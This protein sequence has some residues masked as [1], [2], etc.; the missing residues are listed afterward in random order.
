MEDT[1]PPRFR[2]ALIKGVGSTFKSITGNVSL[3][4]Y[5]T[6][7]INKINRDENAL[8]NL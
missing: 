5:Y 8:K 6:E 7:R 3:A 1:S 4:E 2:R